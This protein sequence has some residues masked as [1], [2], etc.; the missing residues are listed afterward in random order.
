ML[1][2]HAS[3]LETAQANYQSAPKGKA[4]SAVV[5]DLDE[6]DQK[7]DNA[8]QTLVNFVKAYA[9]V[10]GQVVEAAYTKLSDLI[11]SYKNVTKV[12]YEEES[13]QLARFLEQLAKP[14]YQEALTTLNITSHY[15]NLQA[16]QSKFVV[17]YKAR[18]S[19]QANTKIGQSKQ[20]KQTLQAAYDYIID[21]VAV[22]SH[23]QPEH[24]AYQNLKAQLNTIRKRYRASGKKKV[25]KPEGES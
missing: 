25:T 5:K 15:D 8:Y 13:A 24:Q 1:T 22:L 7:R 9:Y 2:T 21:L 10:D 20:Q 18:L 6:A 14:D 12:T 4:A 23:G 11:K 19:E 16:A 17:V 3:R